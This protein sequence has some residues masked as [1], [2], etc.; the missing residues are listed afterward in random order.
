MF[1]KIVINVLKGLIYGGIAAGVGYLKNEDWET[2]DLKK[3]TKTVIIGGILGGIAG[4][5]TPLVEYSYQFGTEFQIP[6]EVVYT[7]AMTSLTM[8]ADQM[9]KLIW[10]KFK[11]AALCKKIK[12]LCSGK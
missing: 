5:G 6:G 3:A 9:V 11:L 12:D 7:F 2:V 10:R 4:S 1:E 8:F